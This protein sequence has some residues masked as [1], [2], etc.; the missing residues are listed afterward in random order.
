MNNINEIQEDMLNSLDLKKDVSN[1]GIY[2]QLKCG[3]N[4]VPNY[5]ETKLL[6]N[7]L[8]LSINTKD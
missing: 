3:H 4:G 5:L 8:N 6:K 1:L 2:I 7:A